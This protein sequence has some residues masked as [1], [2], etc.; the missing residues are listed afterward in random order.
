MDQS[1]KPS[2]RGRLTNKTAW[3]MCFLAPWFIYFAV[4]TAF[5]FLYGIYVSFTNYSIAGIQNIRFVGLENFFAIPKDPAFWRSIVATLGFAALVIP[6]TVALSLWVANLLQCYG[7][8]MNGFMKVFIY[9][10]GVAC[11]AAL[12]SAWKFIF[13]PGA[14]IISSLFKSLGL[15]T[16]SLF[17]SALTSIPVLSLIIV[18]AN[19][20]QPIILYSAAMN[21]IPIT[22]YEAAEIDGASR[23]KQFF[24]ITLPLLQSAN[25]FV[26]VTTTI[27]MFQI[28]IVP[29]LMTGGGPQYRTSTL[30]LMV[31]RSAFQNGSFGY[32][33]AVGLVLFLLTAVVAAFQF[34]MMKRD[35]VE[36]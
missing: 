23:R 4:F 7:T 25:T 31:Y 5:P 12:V 16:F 22:Y 14:G 20:G 27:G 24:S 35:L 13:A 1:V 28:F 2:P 15:S 21:S 3:A 26:I 36:F 8:K 19:L 33:S 30:L 10:P 17:D 9:L 11:Q 18:L 6:L 32:A 34:Y 29:Y